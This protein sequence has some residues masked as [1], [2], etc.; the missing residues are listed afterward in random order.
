MK[1]YWVSWVQPGDDHR[2]LTFPPNDAIL[3][4]WCSGYTESDK[5]ILCALV[6][7]LSE[8]LARAAIYM[9]WPE[10]KTANWRFVNERDRDY[11]P[12]DRFPLSEWMKARIEA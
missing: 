7:A 6:L 2:P 9:D 1:R 10:A 3:G 11:L 8:E 4:W 12:G 5:A